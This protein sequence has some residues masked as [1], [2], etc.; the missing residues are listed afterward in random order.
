MPPLAV[1][2]GFVGGILLMLG[3]A[4]YISVHGPTADRNVVGLTVAYVRMLTLDGPRTVRR[5]ARAV[6]D[7]LWQSEDGN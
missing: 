7:F 3:W 2:V 1:A 5:A 4:L 6:A